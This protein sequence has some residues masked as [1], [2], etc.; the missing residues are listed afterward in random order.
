MKGVGK[1]LLGVGNFLFDVIVVVIVVVVD[2]VVVVYLAS[3]PVDFV[4]VDVVVD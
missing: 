2:V 3:I 4:V 1:R